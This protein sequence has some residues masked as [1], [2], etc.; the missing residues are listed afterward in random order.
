MKN[1]IRQDKKLIEL[2]NN[3]EGI[4]FE[5]LSPSQII[6]YIQT[7]GRIESRCDSKATLTML[8]FKAR[9]IM[10]ELDREL[11]CRVRES[12]RERYSKYSA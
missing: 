6:A 4:H 2:L 10:R 3:L 9:N 12:L 5:L 8:S 7:I 11:K 1:Y